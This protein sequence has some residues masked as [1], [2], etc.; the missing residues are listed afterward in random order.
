MAGQRVELIEKVI[1]RQT[2]LASR[3]PQPCTRRICRAPYSAEASR[4]R[5]ILLFNCSML[6]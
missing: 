1:I 4:A 6:Y 3:L 5:R 2:S